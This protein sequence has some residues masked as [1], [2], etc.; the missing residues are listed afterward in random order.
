MDRMIVDETSGTQP[1][2]DVLKWLFQLPSIATGPACPVKEISCLA[3][4]KAGRAKTRFARLAPPPGAGRAKIRGAGLAITR[5]AGRASVRPPTLTTPAC[6]WA[7]GLGVI[8]I[9]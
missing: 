6:F 3:N 1:S 4:R 2:N 5:G 8:D 9:V 7:V